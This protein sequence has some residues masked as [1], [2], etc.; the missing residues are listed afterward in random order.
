M[1][2]QNQVGKPLLNKPAHDTEL[3]GLD[4]DYAPNA[5]ITADQISKAEACI[6]GYSS[7]SASENLRNFLVSSASINRVVQSYATLFTF[8]D[9]LFQKKVLVF[10]LLISSG[11]EDMKNAVAN[12]MGIQSKHN[13]SLYLKSSINADI[14]Y[15]PAL[16]QKL[17]AA[18]HQ[19]IE[20]VR[21]TRD[22]RAYNFK[23]ILDEIAAIEKAAAK[24]AAPSP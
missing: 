9:T 12:V 21:D 23:T 17:H 6:K 13:A 24:P 11:H 2:R 16:R 4:D 3:Y 18:T 1:Q 15:D 14:H 20:R 22:S 19:F 7:D 10:G 8:A 5:V